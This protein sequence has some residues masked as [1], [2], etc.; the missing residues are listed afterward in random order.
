MKKVLIY[1]YLFFLIV[2]LQ[3]YEVLHLSFPIIQVLLIFNLIWWILKQEKRINA[4]QFFLI[5]GFFGMILLSHLFHAYIGGMVYSFLKFIPSFATFL[6]FAHLFDDEEEIGKILGF[7]F[8]MNIVLAIHGIHQFYNNG[9]GWS[10]AQFARG[11]Q[12]I[13]YVGIF[14]DPNDLSLQLVTFLPVGIMFL[15][16]VGS[17][18]KRMVY[19]LAVLC[20][21]YAVYLT[22]SRGGMLALGLMG[23]LY[24]WKFYSKKMAIVIGIIGF[25]G[26]FAISQRAATISTEEE[27]AYGRIEAWYEGIDMLKHSPLWGVGFGM[28]TDYHYLTAHNSFVLCFAELGLVGYFFWLGLIYFSYKGNL[29][30]EYH[31]ENEYFNSL[32]RT[33]G[34]SLLSFLAAAFFLSRTYIVILYLLL[35]IMWAVQ[36]I[37]VKKYQKGEDIFP[38]SGFDVLTIFGI[39]LVSIFIVYVFIKIS[40]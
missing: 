6:I 27:S 29:F 23:M 31:G 28:F 4:P 35:G 30:I 9:L 17:F 34:V 11:T 1:S 13:T 24:T 26:I 38:F 14:N 40:L 32:A 7:I 25:L 15:Q 33:L 37:Y 5:L 8:W 18:L 2:R 36:N 3:D 20:T 19:I 10:G 12:R 39:E 16:K 21:V 22:Q